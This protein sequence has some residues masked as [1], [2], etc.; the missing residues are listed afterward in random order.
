MGLL[1]HER[2]FLDAAEAILKEA[3]A[4]FVQ[5]NDRH[6][7]ASTYYGLG[8]IAFDQ[9]RLDEAGTDFEQ[10]LN[11]FSAVDAPHRTAAAYQGLGRIAEK[12]GQFGQAEVDYL[13]AL[14]VSAAY[15]DMQAIGSV[16]HNVANL[17][18]ATGASSIVNRVAE[19]MSVEIEEARQI[20]EKM[21]LL[22]G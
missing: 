13:K 8:N 1:A 18:A 17:W 16:M 7:A 10:A 2:G 20:I 9:Q 11:I 3:L 19:I 21:A 6:R 12:R 15:K 5:V 4:T 22:S 14:E